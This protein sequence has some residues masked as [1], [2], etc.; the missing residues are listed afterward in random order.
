M[1]SQLHDPSTYA[2]YPSQWHKLLQHLCLSYSLIVLY[3][4]SLPASSFPQV[5]E[6]DDRDRPASRADA[7]PRN[8]RLVEIVMPA[9]LSGSGSA[10]SLSAT[11][12]PLSATV[13]RGTSIK[14]KSSPPSAST[15]TFPRRRGTT[16]PP[17][18]YPAPKRYNFSSGGS[19][20]TRRSSDSRPGSI[21]SY[22]STPS[23]APS[24]SV[25]RHK[26]IRDSVASDP[27]QRRYGSPAPKRVEPVF[28]KPPPF[29]VGKAAVLRVFVPL[30]EKVPR[31][32]SAEGAYWVVKEME[33]CG[34][35]RKLKLG[36]L[37]VSL[38]F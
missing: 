25:P 35:M 2:T 34:A 30:S 8:D 14:L 3:L 26:L 27:G 6:E 20:R 7:V 13:S 9:P 4:R 17:I 32:P 5:D 22:Q 12:A 15:S 29:L 21:F 31:W 24:L 18:S 11:L 33:K 19:I 37:I 38:L 23:V 16:G 36:D 10:S 1:E 28:D